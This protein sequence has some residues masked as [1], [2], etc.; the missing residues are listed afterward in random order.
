M[1]GN[2]LDRYQSVGPRDVALSNK[3]QFLR[4]LVRNWKVRQD[5]AEGEELSTLKVELERLE[6][7]M[8]HK[9]LV[10]E[11][12]WVW[13]ECKKGLGELELHRLKD[14]K[15]RSRVRWAMHGDDNTAYFHGVIN[16]RKAVNAIQGILVDG[17]WVSKPSLVKRE[18]LKFFREHFSEALRVRPTLRCDN[19]NKVP[20]ELVDELI[21]PFSKEDIKEAVFACGADKAPGPD[22]FNFNFIRRFWSFFEEDFFGIL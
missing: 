1:L 9:D 15:Q 22:G 7:T 12:E 11:E 18:I 2:A 20:L 14:L 8:E 4:N 3:F 21:Q 6:A 13:A 16:G 5:A 17:V 19:I 10:E